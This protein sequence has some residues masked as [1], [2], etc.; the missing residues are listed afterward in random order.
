MS[1]KQKLDLEYQIA[2]KIY[3][4][5]RLIEKALLLQKEAK[6]IQQLLD[7]CDLDKIKHHLIKLKKARE[8]CSKKIKNA[9]S[10]SKKKNLEK[11]L[12]LID[13]DLAI[14]THKF[15]KCKDAINAEDKEALKSIK[16]YKSFARRTKI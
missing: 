5:E 14:T 12:K 10:E 4:S 13:R 3:Q 1:I 11:L 16:K 15:I 7:E 6:E 8:G 2:K 9:D